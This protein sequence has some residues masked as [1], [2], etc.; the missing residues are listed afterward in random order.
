V[1][2]QRSFVQEHITI[3]IPSSQGTGTATR[4]P[5][6]TNEIDEVTKERVS[7][8][9]TPSHYALITTGLRIFAKGLLSEG[10][11]TLISTKPSAPF[12]MEPFLLF[13]LR[14]SVVSQ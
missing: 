1:T 2:Q 8:L 13:H 3:E 9:T 11:S 6:A 4:T 12:H 7:D 14:S 10:L 5:T